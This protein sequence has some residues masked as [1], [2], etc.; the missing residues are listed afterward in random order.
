MYK[1]M[2]KDLKMPFLVVIIVL[3]IAVT[4]KRIGRHRSCEII[5][6]NQSK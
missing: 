5:A 2:F 4:A 3:G 1:E 6:Q